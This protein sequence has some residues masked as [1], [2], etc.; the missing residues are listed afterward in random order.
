MKTTLKILGV[1]IILVIGANLYRVVM[2][3][4]KENK[5]AEKTDQ[6]LNDLT[7]LSSVNKY[8]EI[9]DNQETF[10]IPAIKKALKMFYIDHNRYPETIEELNQ[11]GVVGSEATRDRFGNPFELS[12][13]AKNAILSSPG[14]DEIKGTTDDIEIPIPLQ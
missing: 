3:K 5:V 7:G 9:R 6:A 1:F 2:D 12:Y 10:N 13:R 11:A 4:M 8:L 14:K